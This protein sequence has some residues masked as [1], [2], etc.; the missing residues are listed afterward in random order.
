M[1]E[2]IFDRIHVTLNTLNE[3]LNEANPF[4]LDR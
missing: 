1:V 3:Q 4:L 2:T